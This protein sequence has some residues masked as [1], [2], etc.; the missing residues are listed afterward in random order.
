WEV[1]YHYQPASVVS[2]DYCDLISNSDH[3]LLFIIGDVSGKGVAAAMLMAHLQAMVRTLTSFNLP[4]EDMLERASR[5]FCESTLPT[6]FATLACGKASSSGAIEISNAGHLP[7]L[8]LQQGKLKSVEATG[9][10]VG[11]FCSQHFSVDRFQM[12]QGDTLFLY[13]DGF[14]ETRDGSGS[15][16]GLGRLSEVLTENYD[17][18]PKELITT[19]VKE[20]E[21][22]RAQDSLTDDLSLMAIQRVH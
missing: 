6:H 16:Y 15:E 13:T 12:N 5:V 7:P 4:L 19:C 14:S 22:F 3:S 9:L 8:L 17:L 10:P 21:N 18:A 2:G 20:L 1:A 11:V